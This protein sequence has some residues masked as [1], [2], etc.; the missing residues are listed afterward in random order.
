MVF[1][2]FRLSG[3][4][5]ERVIG[6]AG[7]LDTARFKAFVAEELKADVT[8]VDAMVI[9]SHGD[10]MVPLVSSAR[11]NGKP[12]KDLIQKDRM[13]AII[14]RTRKGGEEIVKLLKTGSAFFAPACAAVEMADSILNNR[15]KV[16]PCLAYLDGEYGVNG[17][18]A[19][20]PVELSKKGA[21]VEEITLTE[22][23]QKEFASSV[24]HIQRVVQELGTIL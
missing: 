5:K 11:V 19:G 18:F 12:L 24:V 21:K 4:D 6:M 23:E 13:D 22:A 2:A 14:D 10:L 3:F 16:V 8:K 17:L 1:L 15:F 7:V 20:V 9:G